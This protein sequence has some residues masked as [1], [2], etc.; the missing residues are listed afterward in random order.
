[1]S[2]RSFSLRVRTQLKVVSACD[3]HHSTSS[4]RMHTGHTHS[5]SPLALAD[6][7]MDTIFFL[8]AAL[9]PLNP[10]GVPVDPGFLGLLHLGLPIRLTVEYRCDSSTSLLRM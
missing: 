1:M 6:S 9:V 5:N 8:F 10:R 3:T 7:I 4:V 2:H